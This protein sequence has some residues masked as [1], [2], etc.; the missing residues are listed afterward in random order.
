[1][2]SRR[3]ANSGWR[4]RSGSGERR[5]GRPRCAYCC[6]WRSHNAHAFALQVDKAELKVHRPSFLCSIH[7]PYEQIKHQ[8][9]TISHLRAESAQWKAQLARLEEASREEIADWKERCLRADEERCRLSSRMD[10]LVAEQ[11]A[12]GTRT[13][14]GELATE[15][16]CSITRKPTQLWFGHPIPTYL[17]TPAHRQ[18]A[19]LLLPYIH[20]LVSD[21]LR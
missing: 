11:L 7:S 1:M 9:E 21:K 15:P 8:A 17:S 4:R 14:L 18:N 12:V 10:E 6:W 5:R 2:R 16:A 13:L 20:L 19:L 3:C